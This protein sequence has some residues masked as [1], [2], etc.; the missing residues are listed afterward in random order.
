[1]TMAWLRY[2]FQILSDS[3]SSGARDGYVIL[4]AMYFVAS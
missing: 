3:S 4:C 1:M 2:L